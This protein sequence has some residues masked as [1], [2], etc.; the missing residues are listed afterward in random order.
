MLVAHGHQLTLVLL[1]TF[2]EKSSLEA[3][4]RGV[5]PR[6]IAVKTLPFGGFMREQ[7]RIDAALEAAEEA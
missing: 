6:L 7:S 4:G 5:G 3:K 1:S 2:V